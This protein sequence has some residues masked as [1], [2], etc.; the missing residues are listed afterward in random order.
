MDWIEKASSEELLNNEINNN[1]NFRLK[2]IEI[3]EHQSYE[4][5]VS[6][7]FMLLTLDGVTEIPTPNKQVLK[8]CL[9]E[10]APYFE[11]VKLEQTG[12]QINSILIQH[13]K[14]EH[15]KMIRNKKVHGILADLFKR[16]DKIKK[17]DYSNPIS[18][19]TIYKVLPNYFTEIRD[20]ESDTLFKFLSSAFSNSKDL[21]FPPK[22]WRF[23]DNLKESL[24]IQYSIHQCKSF[25]LWVDDETDTVI[26]IHLKF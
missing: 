2:Q 25:Y 1:L 14:K 3:K 21:L 16:E 22:N 9:D 24:A 19:Y 13:L 17:V 23:S 15:S 11:V 18:N 8:Q 12:E 26:Y 20:L 5:I 10:I 7:F 6:E 4:T